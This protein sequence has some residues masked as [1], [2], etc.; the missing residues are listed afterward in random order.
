V[1]RRRRVGQPFRRPDHDHHVVDQELRVELE[2]REVRRAAAHRDE[3][4]AGALAQSELR[5]RAPGRLRALGDAVHADPESGHVVADLCRRQAAD[6]RRLVAAVRRAAHARH[7]AA[8]LVVRDEEPAQHA[9]EDLDGRLELLRHHLVRAR[10]AQLGDLAVVDRTREH[11]HLRR[12]LV[13]D[14]RD[15]R[16]GGGVVD[17]QH[18]DP[19][20]L[21]AE[22]LEHGDA[23]RV[24][25]FDRRAVR[26]LG[27]HRLRV[28]LDGHRGQPERA[29]RREHAA[30]R[31]A[32][33][34]EDRVPRQPRSPP[35]AEPPRAEPPRAGPPSR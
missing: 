19:R 25:V 6:R 4:A 5:D 18:E 24:A 22:R 31:R 1:E 27:A 17:R 23:R 20:A 9:H 14:L 21:D 32:E 12:Q 35:R 8:D 13:R 2:R 30:A 3:A 16:R 28:R 10:R 15:P 7:V 34:D 29:Q 33:A 26:A 11:V